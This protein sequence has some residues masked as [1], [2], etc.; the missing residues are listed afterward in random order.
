MTRER[1]RDTDSLTVADLVQ[2]LRGAGL[3]LASH[4]ADVPIPAGDATLFDRLA[5]PT[6][7]RS[8]ILLGVGVHPTHPTS[9][10]VVRDAAACGFAAVVVKA[11]SADIDALAA[12]ADAAGIALMVADDG[13]DWRQLAALIDSA[14]AAHGGSVLPDVAVGD[15]FALADAVAAMVGGATTIEDLQERVLA[16]STVPGQAIDDD[17]RAGI[18]GRQVPTLPGNVSQYAHVFRSEGAVRL[19][20]DTSAQLPRLAVAVRVGSQ[21]LGSIWVIDTAEGLPASAER[22]LEQAADIA[23]LHLLRARSAADL[24]RQRRTEFLRRLLQDENDAHLLADQ[25]GLDP[26][27]R[28]VVVALQPELTPGISQ[29][30]LAQLSDFVAVQCETYR[31]GTQCVEIGTTVYALFAL[32]RAF[33]AAAVAEVTSRLVSRVQTALRMP[34][35]S[36]LGSTAATI[37][38]VGASR[39]DADL[40]LLLLA[41][42][43]EA[44][45][46]ASADDVRSALILLEL[47][48]LLHTHPHVVSPAAVRLHA[49]DARGGTHYADTVRTYLDCGRD[50]AAAAARLSLHQNT[51]RYRLRR[52]RDLAGVDLDDPDDTLVLW[53]ALRATDLT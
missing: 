42:R 5:P 19:P 53:L 22:A 36:A 48:Q 37:G 16:Y 39:H 20:A 21:P 17:R 7:R 4:G 12:V 23:A 18:L 52:A 50:S 45:P 38:R 6:G 27:G 44:V 25:M 47:G 49:L 10:A 41:K 2:G 33:D 34:V 9:P 32:D 8:G 11:L 46:V 35:A 40:V 31:P 29:L 30:Q 3:R 15:L 14:V 24:A 13:A 51:L 28:F 43:G 26:L 1:R